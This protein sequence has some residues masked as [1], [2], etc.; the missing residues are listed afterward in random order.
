MNSNMNLN[1][2]QRQV[3]AYGICISAL[4]AFLA[5]LL[6]STISDSMSVLNPQEIK[7]DIISCIITYWGVSFLLL[8][9]IVFAITSSKN[10][11]HSKQPKQDLKAITPKEEVQSVV[12]SK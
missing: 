3:I 7:D 10:L 4:L 12:V 5:F 1:R 8:Y 2:K 6:Y 11:K 9:M